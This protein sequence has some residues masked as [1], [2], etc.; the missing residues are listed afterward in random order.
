MV[1]KLSHIW[2][3][4]HANSGTVVGAN[5][6]PTTTVQGHL[7]CDDGDA[8]DDFSR[9]SS[10]A[11]RTEKG[12]GRRRSA[13]TNG[14]R[15]R[16]TKGKDGNMSESR[17]ADGQ[18]CVQGE[19]RH[20][21]SSKDAQALSAAA[22]CLAAHPIMDRCVCSCQR[23][24]LRWC[25]FCG[26]GHPS[27]GECAWHSDCSPRALRFR[28]TSDLFRAHLTSREQDSHVRKCVIHRRF[29][30]LGQGWSQIEQKAA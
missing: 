7:F 29:H 21:A 11:G 28:S 5:A 23:V 10:G 26:A 19:G 24:L 13:A 8:G 15:G 20:C 3:E 2:R 25:S 6:V 18:G 30:C 16:A 27:R 9:G 22:A 17:G 1:E 14:G 4:L 12:G